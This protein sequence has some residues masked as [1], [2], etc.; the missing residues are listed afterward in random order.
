MLEFFIMV[1]FNGR[2]QRP[3][4]ETKIEKDPMTDPIPPMPGGNTHTQVFLIKNISRKQDF[5]TFIAHTCKSVNTTN[6][7]NGVSFL[8]GLF[9]QW[10][11]QA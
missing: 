1:D 4:R 10:A 6:Q 5:F 11:L 9:F 2:H 3:W 7:T 8:L